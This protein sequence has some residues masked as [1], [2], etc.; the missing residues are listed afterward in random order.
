MDKIVQSIDWDKILFHLN[1]LSDPR[2]MLSVWEVPDGC[3]PIVKHPL[4]DKEVYIK[5][6]NEILFYIPLHK[7]CEWMHDQ[8]TKDHTI[9]YHTEIA[10][11]IARE[12]NALFKQYLQ[13]QN[14]SENA[15]LLGYMLPRFCH[16][17]SDASSLFLIVND[18]FGLYAICDDY[19]QE[20]PV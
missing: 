5:Y 16:I 20:C 10:K 18:V 2:R 6:D 9:S 3:P 19:F 17:H 1:Y 12:E 13:K 11:L 4:C 7:I 14:L 15:K 8:K